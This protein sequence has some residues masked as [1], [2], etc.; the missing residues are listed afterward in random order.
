M[1]N[2]LGFMVNNTNIG[3]YDLIDNL[4]WLPQMSVE[5]VRQLLD[6]LDKQNVPKAVS[7]IQHLSMLDQAFVRGCST[8]SDILS[9]VF[10]D[11]APST[12]YIPPYCH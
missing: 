2:S 8:S 10:S 1:Q 4:S 3:P 6:L 11:N 12:P 5:E 9:D 7:L